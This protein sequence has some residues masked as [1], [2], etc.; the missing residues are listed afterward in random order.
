MGRN[1]DTTANSHAL[2]WTKNDRVWVVP[3]C[4]TKAGHLIDGPNLRR[5]RRASEAKRSPL[6]AGVRQRR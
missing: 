6:H 3:L 5:Q 1:Y 2:A 4:W